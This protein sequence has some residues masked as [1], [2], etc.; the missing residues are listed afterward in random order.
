MFESPVNF[1]DSKAGYTTV[2]NSVDS[3]DDSDDDVDQQSSNE[4]SVVQTSAFSSGTFFSF[5]K[6]QIALLFF[7]LL[8]LWL[9]PSSWTKSILSLPSSVDT[10]Y[11]NSTVLIQQLQWKKSRIDELELEINRTKDS[12]SRSSADTVEVNK[13]QERIKELEQQILGEEKYSQYL[14]GSLTR[15]QYIEKRVE[16]LKPYKCGVILHYHINKCAG[17]SMG[18]W[19]QSR[20]LRFKRLYHNPVIRDPTQS[21]VSW[22]KDIESV[23]KWLNMTMGSGGTLLDMDENSKRDHW[24]VLE[25]H[26]GIPGMYYLKEHLKKW[27]EFIESKGCKFVKTTVLRDPIDR[28]VSNIIYNRADKRSNLTNFAT[29]RAN[30]LSRYLM[31]GTCGMYNGTIRCGYNRSG[32]FTMTPQEF[33]FNDVV[34]IIKD[35]DIVGLVSDLDWHKQKIEEFTGWTTGRKAKISHPTKDRINLTRPL[36][37]Q[38]IRENEYDNIL[39]YGVIRSWEDKRFLAENL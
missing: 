38:M 18:R 31:Y 8:T 3:N 5:W 32:K 35:F 15:H 1:T 34:S 29:S 36:L 39:Y 26:H 20:C 33:D 6:R 16:M 27:N 14:K 24:A 23:Y 10:P 28:L 37:V 7:T 25:I 2:S 4:D 13:L 12:S 9:I 22:K 17:D 21:K 30:W 11:F 19:F